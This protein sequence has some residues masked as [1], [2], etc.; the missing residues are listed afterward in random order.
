MLFNWNAMGF[1]CTYLPWCPPS[2]AI[3][4]FGIYWFWLSIWFWFGLFASCMSFWMDSIT[5]ACFFDVVVLVT[6]SLYYIWNVYQNN[7]HACARQWVLPSNLLLTFFCWLFTSN[8][9]VRMPLFLSQCQI[10]TRW[11]VN[12]V[13]VGCTVLVFCSSQHWLCANTYSVMHYD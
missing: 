3:F 8:F 1:F 5:V 2:F 6:C 12:D 13:I 10:P 4:D 11:W 7:L 9:H